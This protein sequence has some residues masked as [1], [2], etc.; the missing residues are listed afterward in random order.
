MDNYQDI[1]DDEIRV[2]EKTA[3]PK[4]RTE[5]PKKKKTGLWYILAAFIAII[6]LITVLV[7][8][9]YDREEKIDDFTVFYSK[10]MWL[11]SEVDSTKMAYVQMKD[12]VINDVELKVFIPHNVQMSLA[13][14]LPNINDSSVVFATR[15]ADIRADNGGIVAD[16]VIKGELLSRGVSKKGFCS[17]VG[18]EIEIGM[19]D[20]SALVKG[21]LGKE[22]GY[23]FR[24]YPLVY[25]GVL[26][27][28]EPKGKSIRR[29]ICERK[30]EVFMVSSITRESFHDFAQALVDLDIDN[31]IYL[32]GSDVYG[33]AR[34]ESSMIY[35][36]GTP[37]PA[38]VKLPKNLTYILWRTK[39]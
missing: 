17:S 33:W 38:N 34:D 5:A 9:N 11:G 14:G 32:V 24:Q 15:A 7:I 19:D 12:T 6:V 26:I 22:D 16:C 31:A 35:T 30:G 1:K 37:Y 29:A 23:F 25:N 4:L 39:R 27:N 36:F 2:I 20:N 13:L 8:R 3:S 10:N 21:M 28:N 18:G